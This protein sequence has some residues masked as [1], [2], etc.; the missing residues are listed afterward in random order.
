MFAAEKTSRLICATLVGAA[1]LIAGAWFTVQAQTVSRPVMPQP[2]PERRED[3][4]DFGSREFDART[5]M[6]L[7]QE[8]KNY[9]EHVERAKEARDLAAELAKTYEVTHSFNL[10][11]YKK[12]ERLEKLT[13]RIR[14]EVG[15]SQTDGDPKELPRTIDEAVPLMSAMAKE[16]CEAVENT[17]RRVVSASLID[18]ANKLITLIQYVRRDDD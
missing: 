4:V 14:N 1:I 2:S 8:K 9:E 10:A 13:R 7:K 5:R 16:L 12:L 11:D 18:Q 6:A 15:G 3:K 17:P